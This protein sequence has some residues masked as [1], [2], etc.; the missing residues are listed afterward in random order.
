[1][2]AHKI[3]MEKNRIL[4]ACSAYALKKPGT[5]AGML[6]SLATLGTLGVLTQ[7]RRFFYFISAN[8]W[9]A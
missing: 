8:S 6:P 2:H 4:N 9:R 3:L 7:Y 5:Y 1:M